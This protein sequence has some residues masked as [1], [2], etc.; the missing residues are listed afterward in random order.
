[1][2]KAETRQLFKSTAFNKVRKLYGSN[3]TFKCSEWDERS[4]AE[5]RDEEVDY[6][7]SEL[8]KDLQKLKEASHE[9]ITGSH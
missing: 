1:M 5:Q 2:T 4:Y 9:S 8:E 7:L 3:S 6:I